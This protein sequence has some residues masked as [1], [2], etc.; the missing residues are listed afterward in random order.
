MRAPLNALIDVRDETVSHCC[1]RA[2]DALDSTAETAMATG[3]GFTPKS[4]EI[5]PEPPMNATEGMN[6][7]GH[8]NVPGPFMVV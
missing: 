2:N 7:L 4:L 1:A 3:R 6:Q 5:A 8:S